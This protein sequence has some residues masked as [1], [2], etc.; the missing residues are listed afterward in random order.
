MTI[1][2]RKCQSVLLLSPAD[3]GGGAEQIALALH[4]G[5]LAQGSKSC[6]AA[7]QKKAETPAM[8][9]LEDARFWHPWRS[10][11]QKMA[12]RFPDWNQR[13]AR[14][15]R[16][17]GIICRT[18]AQPRWLAKPLFFSDDFAHPASQR[19]LAELPASP[20]IIHAHNLRDSFFD[21]RLLATW[22]AARP[23]ALTLH[24]ARLFAG[25]CTHP[26]G[27]EKFQV[28]C[29]GCELNML[30]PSLRRWGIHRLM[31]RRQKIFAA[32]RLHVAA[33]ARYL[34]RLAEKSIMKPAIRSSRL[35]ANGVDLALFSPGDRSAARAALRLSPHSFVILFVAAN[36]VYNVA[37]DYPTFCAAVARLR[38]EDRAGDEVQGV[39][40]GSAAPPQPV[41]HILYIPEVEERCELVRWYQ[42]ADVL[43]YTSRM[44]TQPLAIL[45]AM[46]CGL[47]TIASAV[48]GIPEVIED[49]ANGFLTPPGDAA[50]CCA[51]LQRLRRDRSLAAA[52]AAAARQTAEARFALTRMVRDYLAWYE[53]ILAGAAAEEG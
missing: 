18:L 44:D 50:A 13:G 16:F 42:A 33:P 8:V 52:I 1:S 11:W 53:D 32:S 24:D 4:R 41:A 36:A 31:R 23:L 6:L 40:I 25:V 10:F 27:C 21:L 29:R 7:G 45:E 47:P 12:G 51:C 17:L 34:L 37:K 38:A 2:P 49:G 15:H 20:D 14:W 22:S 5:L 3:R 26:L 19:L 9:I 35:I 39:V 28:A 48:G 46:A 30:W 43:L